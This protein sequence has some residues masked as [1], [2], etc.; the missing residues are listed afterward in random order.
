MTPDELDAF[1]LELRAINEF[2]GTNATGMFERMAGALRVAWAD[3][4]GARAEVDFAFESGD[5]SGREAEREAILAI[6]EA[7]PFYPDT[8]TGMRQQWV[9]DQI[10][11][12]IRARRGDG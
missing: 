4:E 5:V 8:H 6:V 9:K 1:E 10:A 3:L 7:Q 2:F 11:A 12:K